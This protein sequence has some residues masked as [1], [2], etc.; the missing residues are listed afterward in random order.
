MSYESRFSFS[1]VWHTFAMVLN[2]IVLKTCANLKET[3]KLKTQVDQ[4]GSW[5]QE[6]GYY[7]KVKTTWLMDLFHWKFKWMVKSFW[8]N[9][10]LIHRSMAWLATSF[11]FSCW[12]H[13]ARINMTYFWK[14]KTH[15]LETQVGGF[16]C[17]KSNQ[18]VCF[19]STF[20]NF[21]SVWCWRNGLRRYFATQGAWESNRVREARAYQTWRQVTLARGK[22]TREIKVS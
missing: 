21:G 7:F 5:I 9:L 4:S 22:E 3:W 20:F 12:V 14:R 19:S 16:V 8:S 17:A 13:L 18:W 2:A 15:I 10:S 1:Y 6:S 11:I